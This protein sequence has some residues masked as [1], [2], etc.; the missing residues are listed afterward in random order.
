[1]SGQNLQISSGQKVCQILKPHFYER[2][3]A[4]MQQKKV[5]KE[6]KN[7]DKDLPF[8]II[9]YNFTQENKLLNMA[10]TLSD[11]LDWIMIFILEFGR[12]H[13]LTMKQ[14]FN[15]LYRYQGMAFL[16]KHYDYVHTQSFT[17][18]VEDITE[19][20]HRKGGGLQ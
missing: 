13:G 17:S 6:N 1:M 9:K 2:S 5:C 11:K 3:T 7:E 14:A 20:C 12:K 16:D 18:M 10:Y 4:M 8:Q 15:Y 19:Y